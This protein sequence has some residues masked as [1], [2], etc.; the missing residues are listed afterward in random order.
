MRPAISARLAICASLL[1]LLA[2]PA[3]PAVAA[4]SPS[5]PFINEMSSAGG[6][7]FEDACGLALDSA[8]DLY[9]AD[10][11]HDAIDVL[12]PSGQLLTRIANESNGNGPCALA[13]DSTGRLYVDNWRAEALRYTPSAYPPTASTTYGAPT[14]IDESGTATGV[15]VDSA[16]NVFVDDTTYIAK[17]DSTG[18]LVTKIGE[19]TLGEGYGVAV[20][21]YPGTAGDLYVPD[22]GAGIVR[23][24]G[25]LGESLPAIDG[26]G[27]PQAGFHYLVDSAV[28]VDNNP[29]SP[30]YGHLFVADNVGHGQSEYPEAA[31]DEFNPAGAYRGQIA[32]WITHPPSEPGVSIEHHL[33]DA[34]PPGL[35]IDSSGRVYVTSDNSDA[36]LSGTVDRNGKPLEGSVLYTFGP[37]SAARTLTVTKSGAGVGTVT[38]A[39]AGINCGTACAAEY[40]EGAKVT[41]TAAPD[42]HSTFL[43][44]S[45]ACSGTTS[46]CQVTMS[47]ARAVG[48]EFGANPQQTLTITETGAGEGT[49]TS[50]PTGL[51]CPG[52]C[53]EHFN[54]GSTVLL[55]AA[56]APHNK[57]VSWTGECIPAEYPN[58]PNECAVHMNAAKSIEA[59]FEAIP[60]RTLTVNTSGEGTVTSA[61]AGIE[62]G[63]SS[64]SEHFD[65]GAT[66]TLTATPATHH[67][68]TWSG[69]GSQPGP[70][71][72][73][74]TMSV[75]ESVSASFAPMQ[76]SLT[77]SVVG[78]GSV[79]ADEGAISGCTDSGGACSGPYPEGEALTL[80]AS[81][82]AGSA[83][84]GWSGA[85][86]GS[87]PCH[88]TIGA[89]AALTA[90]FAAIPSPPIFA[91]LTLGKLVVHGATASL[92]VSLSGPGQLD[93]DGGKA[94]RRDTLTAARAGEMTVHLALSGAGRRA[95]RQTRRD[96]LSVPVA[97]TFTATEGGAAAVA[98][99]LVAFVE[100]PRHHSKHR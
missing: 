5:H 73:K 21:T 82:A 80:S 79:S 25:P 42:A 11:Y 35:A 27:I 31:I 48:A 20:S 26:A 69:C 56:P 77:V 24:F 84:A 60:Q 15:A 33:I 57:L 70:T 50:Q 88:L 12:N 6:G 92:K 64:C 75:A 93:V 17:Y 98:T 99:R 55:T 19:G 51:S 41:L 14:A 40:D 18:T 4:E 16:G 86:G 65:E 61:P 85:C 100:R 53:S 46:G 87:G 34:E 67:Q 52:T 68:V 71:E 28:A 37:T 22:A 2:L 62:C 96:K 78:A 59:K 95:L 30:S 8:G 29:A 54:E 36:S 72:C 94:L 97:L 7:T 43:G 63:A 74:V 13:V 91:R 76:H 32:R 83:F 44:W 23:V 49:V 1:A 89:D 39:P 47:A 90:N 66:V 58:Y 81:P 9:V 10:Y 38:S 3:A 45:G